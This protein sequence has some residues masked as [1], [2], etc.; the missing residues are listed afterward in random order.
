[1]GGDAIERG[2]TMAPD[3]RD[4]QVVEHALIVEVRTGWD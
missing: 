1:M 2:C 4:N 3:D